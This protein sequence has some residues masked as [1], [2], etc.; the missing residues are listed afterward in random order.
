MVRVRPPASQM[1]VFM[2][3]LAALS[4]GAPSLLSAQEIPKVGEERLGTF[5]RAFGE[6]SLTRDQFY[7]RLGRAHDDLARRE[8]R[9]QMEA[10]ISEILEEHGLTFE[11]YQRLNVVVSADA[12]QRAVFE[13]LLEEF[14]RASGT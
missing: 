12:E 3:L 10:R 8:L 9:A 1:G 14:L 5:A 4:A 11:E 13:R 7:D 2:A 6:I